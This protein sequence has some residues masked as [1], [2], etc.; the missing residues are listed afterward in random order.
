VPAAGK[1]MSLTDLKRQVMATPVVRC[2]VIPWSLFGVSM[3]GY[4]VFLSLGLAAFAL[5]TSWRAL[6]SRDSV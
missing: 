5:A 2:D 1:T 4:N 3:A 6:T